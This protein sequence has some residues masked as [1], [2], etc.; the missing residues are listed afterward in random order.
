MR[1][2]GLAGLKVTTHRASKLEPPIPVRARL[3]GH[4]EVGCSVSGAS[5]VSHSNM[6]NMAIRHRENK[7]RKGKGDVEVQ[8]FGRLVMHQSGQGQGSR[9]RH[10]NICCTVLGPSMS[11]CANYT[12]PASFATA[13]RPKCKASLCNIVIPVCKKAKPA[14]KPDK[15][16]AVVAR[17][18]GLE[19]QHADQ[20]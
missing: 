4:K 20:Y 14:K 5:G 10:R 7:Q 18:C 3:K 1:T 9:V 17:F 6:H 19:D 11:S 12:I 2:S 13:E 16:G 8:V 15:Y